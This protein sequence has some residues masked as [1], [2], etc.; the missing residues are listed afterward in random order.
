M[1]NKEGL[2][3]APN[4]NLMKFLFDYISNP[5]NYI[6]LQPKLLESLLNLLNFFVDRGF[7]LIE[8]IAY[9]RLSLFNFLKFF[10]SSRFKD[11]IEVIF[12]NIRKSKTMGVK[13][14]SLNKEYLN[15]E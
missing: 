7:L 10:L 13:S 14:N 4:R 12:E 15:T 8:D 3:K 1:E 5:E 2:T 6:K 11:K 9:A